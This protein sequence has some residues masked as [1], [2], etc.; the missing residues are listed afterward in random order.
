MEKSILVQVDQK[1][2][3]PIPYTNTY[4]LASHIY[5]RLSNL[6][7]FEDEN[8]HDRDE[9]SPYT[10]SKVL[11]TAKDKR[12]DEKGIHSSRWSFIVRSL[13]P[14]IIQTLRGAFAI[15]PAIVVGDATGTVKNIISPKKPDFTRPLHF[16]T[17]SPV[18]IISEELTEGDKR[19]LGPDHPSYEKVL[20]EKIKKSF[21]LHTEEESESEVELWIDKYSKTQ[22]RVTHRDDVFLPAW[23]L[24]GYMRGPA[25]VLEHAYLGGIGAKTALGL[26]CW[27]VINNE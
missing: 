15:D 24:R 9:W 14:Q 4:F 7:I 19:V 5:H 22:V 2:S 12:F 3:A 10:V 16:R 27:D 1:N 20:A 23:E 26:G 11:P 13:D 6:K 18:M 25:N 17:L 21:T 8:L